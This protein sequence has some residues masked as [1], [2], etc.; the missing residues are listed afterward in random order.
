MG[1]GISYSLVYVDCLDWVHTVVYLRIIRAI[2][3]GGIAAGVYIGMLYI[4]ADDNPT[5]YFFHFVMPSFIISFFIYGLFPVICQKCKLVKVREED[6]QRMY[7]ELN[8][9][10]TSYT[11]SYTGRENLGDVS[12]GNNFSGIEKQPVANFGGY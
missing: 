8:K 12:N 2:L 5:K 11:R 3:G 1:F 4:P 9:S 10:V 7:S 6:K